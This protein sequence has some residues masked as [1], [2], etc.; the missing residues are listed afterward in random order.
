M[1]YRIIEPNLLQENEN[2]GNLGVSDYLLCKWFI[3]CF[4][5]ILSDFDG[6]KVTKHSKNNLIWY[7]ILNYWCSNKILHLHAP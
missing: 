6:W 4:K 3:K 7:F 5:G 2:K 1:G